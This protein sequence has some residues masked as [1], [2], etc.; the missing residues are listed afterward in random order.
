MKTC[1]LK[2][3]HNNTWTGDSKMEIL[4]R[5]SEKCNVVKVNSEGCPI[6]EVTTSTSDNEGESDRMRKGSSGV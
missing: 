5:E 2:M 6:T 1:G 4:S 3:C